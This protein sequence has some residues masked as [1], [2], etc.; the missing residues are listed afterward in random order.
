MPRTSTLVNWARSRR[1]LD[2]GTGIGLG[3]KIVA[4]DE[5]SDALLSSS[6]CVS[7]LSEGELRLIPTS[8]VL[9]VG[10][11]LLCRSVNIYVLGKVGSSLPAKVDGMS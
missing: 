9:I 10:F 4:L 1:H 2:L 3:F 5:E 8:W 6:K 7:S 11:I